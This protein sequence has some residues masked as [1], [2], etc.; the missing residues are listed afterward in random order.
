MIQAQIKLRLKVKQEVVLQEWL[1]NLTSV[2]NWAIRKIE[3][4]AKDDIYYSPKDFRNLLANHGEKLGIPS[5]TLQGV[6]STAYLAWTQCFK[7]VA[8]KPRLKGQRNK[9][10]SIPFPDPFRP[11]NE[12]H[13]CVPGLGKIRFHKQEI[14]EGKI[15]CGRIVKRA[16][17]W[18]LCLFIDAEPRHIDC[19]ADGQ[20]GIDP[21]FQ[22]L[23]TT[24]EGEIIEHPRE[25]EI[26]ASR[27]AQAQRGNNQKLVARLQER[28]RNR[29]KDRNHK[30][31]RR[32]VAENIL[33]A[34]SADNHRGIACKFGKSVTSSA[35]AQLRSMLSYK[36]RA[37]GRTYIEVNPRN[38]TKTCSACGALTGPTG[39]T[40]LKVRQWMCN[41]CGATHDRDVNAARNTLFAA[42]GTRVE[43]IYAYA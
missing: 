11:A 43:G 13:I 2:W 42:L 7:K 3:L 32:L 25:L 38:S 40:G 12:N 34:V 23:I 8:K 28:M 36:C 35:H 1:W 18:Y 31:S 16:S 14:P 22:S 17:G 26:G 29:R 9:L 37:G 39:W 24:S 10:N 41:G 21:G 5:H 30:L 19:I 4:D 15:K 27:L 33:I 6:L 20:I